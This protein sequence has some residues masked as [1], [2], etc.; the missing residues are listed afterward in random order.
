MPNPIQTFEANLKPAKLLLHV[1][2]LL[3]CDQI[4]T[5]TDMVQALRGIVQ[6]E[7]GED[8]M[9]VYNQIFLGLVRENAPVKQSDL[10]QT[11]LQNLLR[12]AVVA[13]CTGLD[14]FLPAL[15]RANLMTVIEARGRSFLN[16]NNDDKEFQDYFKT[17]EFNLGDT[18][19]I[20]E[21][22]KDAPLFIANKILSFMNFPYLSSSKGINVVGM[23]LSLA[24]TWKMIA[25]KLDRD[26]KELQRV[27]NAT[28]ERRNDIVHRA[29][30][31]NSD[32]DGPIRAIDYEWTA[33]AVDTIYV[34]CLTLDNLIRVQMAQLRKDIQDR[35]G[36]PSD[37]ED[38]AP[39]GVS[40]QLTELDTALEERAAVQKPLIEAGL[41]ILVDVQLA[42]LFAKFQ[43]QVEI[44]LEPAPDPL[45][46]YEFLANRWTSLSRTWLATAFA[47]PPVG[48]SDG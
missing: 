29:D 23:L 17:L 8:L 5:D 35:K 12:Q 48:G 21:D 46:L 31:S 45:L 15:L 41:D 14:A 3:D 2:R 38:F 10:K 42:D 36:G 9:L 30:R 1:Y 22:P 6:A 4:E 16:F 37:S 13:A 28:A 11:A 19:R 40:E 44:S 33:H 43:Q 47:A 39:D 24:N 27:I 26:Q 7:P 25:T 18:L 20:L 34:V 32:L